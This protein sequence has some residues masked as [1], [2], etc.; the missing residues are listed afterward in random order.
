[1]HT[2]SNVRMC[3]RVHLC[4]SASDGSKCQ[5][6]WFNNINYHFVGKR[7]DSVLG[8]RIAWTVHAVFVLLLSLPHTDILGMWGTSMCVGVAER[9]GKMFCCLSFSAVLVVYLAHSSQCVAFQGWVEERQNGLKQGKRVEIKMKEERD[10][11]E[12]ERLQ[13][14]KKRT[15]SSVCEK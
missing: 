3:S 10:K 8:F 5:L 4:L 13:N 9:W 12:I 7:I 1:M 15:E 2:S 14:T 11:G 6:L